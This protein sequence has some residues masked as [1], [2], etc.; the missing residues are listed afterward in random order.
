[1]M[2]HRAIASG[3]LT[4]GKFL[5]TIVDARHVLLS[6]FSGVAHAVTN[7][8]PHSG[9]LLSEGAARGG[10]ISCPGHFWRF[11]LVTGQK[12]GDPSTH[13]SVYTTHENEG[14]IEVELPEVVTEKS[15]REILLAS[16][17]GEDVSKEVAR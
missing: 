3:E 8:C 6:R 13:L 17:R 10:C 5:A 15:L 11:D 7:V 14:W 16:A 2:R 9:F 1:M 12:Q 4:E